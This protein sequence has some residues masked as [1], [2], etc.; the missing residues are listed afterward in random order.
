MK[1][2]PTATVSDLDDTV[3]GFTKLVLELHN[4]TSKDHV[5]TDQLINYDYPISMFD[6]FKSFE[7][8]GLYSALDILPYALDA[9]THLKTIKKQEIIFLTAR[10][11]I[12]G[13]ETYL[14]LLKHNVPF[15][16]LIFSK[17]KVGEIRKLQRKYHISLFVDDKAE[18][19]IDV[20]ERCNVDTCCIV[21]QTHNRNLELDPDIKRVYNLLEILK[22]AK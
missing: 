8:H 22:Y 5:T 19:V 2:K 14:W 11:E 6:T 21:D 18:N 10:K 20:F 15:T 16:Q 4:K 3:T 13:H 9:I 7:S 12:Y 17:D 1:I